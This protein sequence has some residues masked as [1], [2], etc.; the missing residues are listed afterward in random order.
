MLFPGVS[1]A[2]V[3]DIQS[4][5][6]FEVFLMPF[7][8]ECSRE[9]KLWDKGAYWSPKLQYSNKGNNNFREKEVSVTDQGV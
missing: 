1:G 8:K 4:R 7:L 5:Y 6:R 9:V 2:L 3:L